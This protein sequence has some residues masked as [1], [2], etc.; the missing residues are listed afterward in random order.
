M[1][2]LRAAINNSSP[3]V[4]YSKTTCPNK[5]CGTRYARSELITAL[6][7]YFHKTSY[8]KIAFPELVTNLGEGV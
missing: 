7:G 1:T 4:A 2:E 3:A 6:L 5:T 8:W